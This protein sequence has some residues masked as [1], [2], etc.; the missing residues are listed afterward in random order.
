MNKVKDYATI[1]SFAVNLDGC[2]G[3]CN[4]LESIYNRVCVLNK[5]EDIN[6]RIFNTIT[7]INESKILTKHVSCNMDVNLLL[8]NET[9]IK[10]GIMINVGASMQKKRNSYEKDF[11]WNPAICSCKNGKISQVILT[12]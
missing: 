1:H 4:T 10:I 9:R 2:A 6:V 5:A 3:I 7:R 8:E 12:I 11:I